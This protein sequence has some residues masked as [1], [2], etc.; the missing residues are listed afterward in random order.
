MIGLAAC[1]FAAELLRASGVGFGASAVRV[2][3]ECW[4]GLGA[5]LGWTARR[6]GSNAKNRLFSGFVQRSGRI[7]SDFLIGAHALSAA[8]RLL[9]RDCGFYR[10]YFVRLKVLDPS[11]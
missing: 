9:M 4:A 8:A 3:C 10:R 7:A 2:S 1:Y 11:A 5:P 6:T